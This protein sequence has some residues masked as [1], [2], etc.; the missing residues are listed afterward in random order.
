M[1][2]IIYGP[3]EILRDI[4]VNARDSYCFEFIS[5]E[6]EIPDYEFVEQLVRSNSSLLY[7]QTRRVL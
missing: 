2:T 4:R 5:L 7:H 1:Y 3:R 6:D